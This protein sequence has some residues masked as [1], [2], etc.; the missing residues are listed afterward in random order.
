MMTESINLQSSFLS[1][2]SA[3]GFIHQC[4]DMEALDTT[5]RDSRMTFYI[6]FDATAKSLQVGNLVQIM[7]A[8]LAQRHGLRPLI[9]MGGG[10]TKIG[11]PSGKTELRKILSDE[12]IQHN[13]DSIQEI[14]KNFL[15]FGCQDNQ[16]E[17]R[18]NETWL[19]PLKFIPFLRDYGR[20]F[21]INRMLTF[22]S[23]RLRLE[24]EQPLSFIE[25]N[26]MIFQAYDFL[27]LLRK[28]Q[29][30][31]QIG[32]SDQ[33]GNIV[34]GV[35]LVRRI[36]NKVVFGLTTPLI[37][38]ASGIKMGKTAQGAIWLSEA[39]LSPYEYWQFW[40][41]TEDADVEKFLKLF[42]DLPLEEIYRLCADLAC[43][44]DAKKVLADEATAL[45]HG[46]EKMQKAHSTAV[47][48]FETKIDLSEIQILERDSET[49]KIRIESTLPVLE[50][51]EEDLKEKTILDFFIESGMGA[52]KG[53]IRR[54]IEGKGARLNDNPIEDPFYRLSRQDFTPHGL[55][56]LSTGKKRHTLLYLCCS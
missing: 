31:L 3:R 14:F 7:I 20:Y 44:N 17:M 51:K 37:T 52:S 34:S 12:E 9:L 26:Y 32:G 27:E 5:L 21:S 10:T 46:V 1:E 29:C 36:E 2:A 16:A 41:N 4:T 24:R 25:F 53:E 18:N 40:R 30:M 45:V 48:L 11:D 35:D 43:L 15:N 38:T 6:G 49:G 54:L 39:L 28:D 23:I 56:K 55:L 33:W 42:T 19:A 50:I 8:R 13:I 47:G 22:D